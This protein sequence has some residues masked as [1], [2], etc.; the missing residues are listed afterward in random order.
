[1]SLPSIPSQPFGSYGISIKPVTEAIQ[2]QEEIVCQGNLYSVTYDKTNDGIQ[3]KQ[4]GIIVGH[5]WSSE[6]LIITFESGYVIKITIGKGI[7]G[8]HRTEYFWEPMLKVSLLL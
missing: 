3:F 2:L 1:M 5:I 6:N 4:L 8:C 7:S